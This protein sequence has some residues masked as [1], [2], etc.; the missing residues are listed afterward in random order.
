MTRILVCADSAL[1]DGEAIKVEGPGE[2][3]AVFRS[4]GELYA[5]ADRCSHGNASMSEGY[6]EDNG[7]VECPLHAARFCLKTGTALCQPATE[8][9]KTFPVALLDGQIYVDVPEAAA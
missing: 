4:N 1:P 2:A 6:V 3:V 5:L 9:L 7:T 8:A